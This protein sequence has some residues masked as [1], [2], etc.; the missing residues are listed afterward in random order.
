MRKKSKLYPKVISSII[1][2]VLVV[3]MLALIPYRKSGDYQKL[4]ISSIETS[5]NNSKILH[6]AVNRLNELYGQDFPYPKVDSLMQSVMKAGN[7]SVYEANK[8]LIK[9]LEKSSLSNEDNLQVE[10]LYWLS[11][12]DEEKYDNWGN[13]EEFG[14]LAMN[15]IQHEDPFIRGMAE[16]AIS[17]RI[18]LLNNE[19]TSVWP[20]NEN[21]VPE[22]FH[23]WENLLQ[24]D[25]VLEAD[26]VRQGVRKDMHR[27][28]A[29]ILANAK[30]IVQRSKNVQKKIS[31]KGS[32][33]NLR[34]TKKLEKKLLG[35]H[36]KLKE[37]AE[38]YPVKITRQ[39][40]I[41]LNMRK[42]ARKIVLNNPDIKNSG[43][44]LFTLRHTYHTLSNI[45]KGG[46]S[47]NNKPGGDIYIKEG[48]T[49]AEGMHPLIKDKF[50]RGH[51][52]GMDLSY[53]ADKLVFSY[54]KQP[55][56]FENYPR[57][58]SASLYEINLETENIRTLT[59][60]PYNHDLEPAYLPDGDIVFSSTRSNFGSQCAGSFFQDRKITNMYKMDGDGENIKSLSNNKD[61]DRYP[62]VMDNG[63][64]VYTRWEYQERHLWQVHNLWACRPD[65]SYREPL[66]KQHNHEG[67]YG[68]P[69][70]LRDARDIPNSDKLVA[71]GTGHHDWAQGAVYLLDYQKG[72]NEPDGFRIVTP[73]VAEFEGGLGGKKIVD[74]GG[75]IDYGGLYQKP[76]PLSEESFLVSYSYYP[77]PEGRDGFSNATNFGLY[78]ID[79]WGNKELIHRD[80]VLSVA[81]PMVY[82]KRKRPPRLA[83]K[84]ENNTPY[85]TV[86]L[87]DITQGVP[88]L[89]KE[90]VRYIRIGH[91]TEWPA[92]E[93]TGDDPTAYN[94]YHYI[95]SGSWARV[96]GVWT[97]SPA[98]VIGTVPVE[99]DGSAHFKVPAD[100][101]VYFQALD[102]NYQEIRRM[103]SFVTFQPGEIR[104]CTGCHESRDE[105]PY[106]SYQA[107][108]IPDAVK[109]KPSKPEPPAWGNTKLP[110]FERDIQPIFSKNCVS[111]HGKKSPKAGLE[112]TSR[113][114]GGLNQA[115]RTLFGLKPEETTPTWQP[116]FY[117]MVYPE[118]SAKGESKEEMKDKLELMQENKYP[119]QLVSIANRLSDNSVTQVKQF[120]S[121]QSKL[122]R[123]LKG[124]AHQKRVDL[125]REEWRSL[126]TWID[127]NAP[128]WGSFVDKNPAKY[129]DKRAKRVFVR[130]PHPFES[131]DYKGT[132]VIR[133]TS[134]Y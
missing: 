12:A 15:W 34:K 37:V 58:E 38:K 13:I 78:Y 31:S 9:H 123:V 98:R 128:Y 52:R 32:R 103:R 44:F 67:N 108:K 47:Y 119:G 80:P 84:V 96:V 21:K 76:Y 14:K 55:N 90:D 69:M 132:E 43:K 120:G 61:F 54:V 22:W 91:H 64:I 124:E 66:F 33:K 53:D 18:N 30:K 68:G 89:N 99:N 2:I 122:I 62:H 40:T 59:D 23:A 7:V 49:P 56:Y 70:S 125:S 6:D 102:E 92:H 46:K 105:A 65:G 85:A 24:T 73:E 45:T 82:K 116:R 130:Y 57:C 75:V 131:A 118:Y 48:L 5:L 72:T 28:S 20:Q 115:Y 110:D 71:I 101:P 11:R 129:E 127:L 16:W 42:T 104:G 10:L 83:G 36:E 111:C 133:K 121:T 95:P 1:L 100:I 8:A 41:W 74:E 39:R 93:R 63:K 25:F 60:H 29:D 19:F 97:W 112:F 106:A 114:F 107:H 117:K 51:M 113:E 79:V 77:N 50:P 134:E 126:V 3:T 26:Y 109:R 17:H 81:Y 88:E 35:Q 94:D 86:Y 87:P 4:D 27:S